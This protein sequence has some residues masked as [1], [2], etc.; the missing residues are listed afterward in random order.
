MRDILIA[1]KKGQITIEEVEKQLRLFQIE[2]IEN[3]AKL[4]I[5]RDLRKGIPEI[6]YGYSKEPEQILRI[7]RRVLEKKPLV[8]VSRV[9]PNAITLLQESVKEDYQIFTSQYSPTVV[10]SHKDYQTPSTGGCVG[11]LTGGTSDIPVADEAMVCVNAMGCKTKTAFDV[12]V[13]GIHRLFPD[14]KRIIEADAD[15]LIVAAGMEG[16]LPSVVTGLVDI[17]VIGVPV[18]TGY[19]YGGKGIGALTTMLQ[20]CALGLTVVNVD[21]GIAAGATAALIANR[22]AKSRS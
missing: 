6:I 1:Y 8:I 5:H 15:V 4:D 19:G 14:L 21:N 9:S 13:A 22:C 7:A 2:E 17:P 12:G 11:I 16:A 20:S 10:L 18:S 3:L